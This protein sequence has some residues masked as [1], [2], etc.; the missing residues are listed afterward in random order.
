MSDYEKLKPDIVACQLEL[1]NIC[2]LAS[3]AECA[4]PFMTRPKGHMDLELAKRIISDCVDAFGPIS[5]NL[6]GLGEPLSYPFLPE[7]IR[8]IGDYS[9]KSRIEIFTS[10]VCVSEKHVKNVINALSDVSN[11]I[12]LASSY[13]I[14]NKE[15]KRLEATK[16]YYRF[17]DFYDAFLGNNRIDFH[18]A[19]NVT[20]WHTKAEEKLFLNTFTPFMPPDK[21]HLIQK[22]DSWFGH[23]SDQAVDTSDVMNPNVCDYPFRVLHIGWDGQIIICCTDDVDSLLNF[24]YIQDNDVSKFWRSPEMEEIRDRHNNLDVKNLTPCNICGRTKGY[25]TR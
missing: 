6:N 11:N 20:K 24:G 19:M 4:Y 22:L 8:Y 9:P 16:K 21:V 5:F 10:L 17:F 18:V 12:L 2:P 15:G 13:H 7:V 3:C 23:V 25:I 14:M 1:T